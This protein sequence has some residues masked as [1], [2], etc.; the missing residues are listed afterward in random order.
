MSRARVPEIVE[1][2]RALPVHDLILDGEAIA[3]YRRRAPSS[4]SVTM[5]RFG[6][7]ARMSKRL[8]PELPLQAFFF[9]C[10][11]LEWCC[12]S[13]IARPA[14]AFLR[15][16]ALS[17]MLRIPRLVTSLRGR[18]SVL[19]RRAAAGHEGVM[20]KALEAP[21]EAGNRGASWLKIKRGTRSTW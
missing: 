7:Q 8:R 5:R 21:Y 1:D 10:L 15:S 3:V 2:V 9:D 6:R 16:R 4:V 11:R 19:R 17:R 13:P 14:S 12:V 18:R 20:A